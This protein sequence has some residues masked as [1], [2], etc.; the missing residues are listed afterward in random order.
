MFLACT[1]LNLLGGDVAAAF[2]GRETA[3]AMAFAR[4]RKR[5]ADMATTDNKLFSLYCDGLNS[6]CIHIEWKA[7]E[8]L[9]NPADKWRAVRD[10]PGGIQGVVVLALRAP[11]V[12]REEQRLKAGQEAAAEEARQKMWQGMLADKRK[13]Q[14]DRAV[15]VIQKCARQVMRRKEASRHWQQKTAKSGLERQKAEMTDLKKKFTRLQ[16][17]LYAAKGVVDH[18]ERSIVAYG[19]Q[20]HG[21]IEE[22]LV[23]DVKCSESQKSRRAAISSRKHKEAGRLLVE[24]ERYDQLRKFCQEQQDQLRVDMEQTAMHKANALQ[25]IAKINH[26]IKDTDMGMQRLQRKLDGG[27]MTTGY[28]RPPKHAGTRALI[29]ARERRFAAGC[30]DRL[31][32]ARVGQ[33]A[34]EIEAVAAT[35]VQ[36][37]VRAQQARTVLMQR[38][39]FVQSFV[40]MCEIEPMLE[41]R[42]V[43]LQAIARGV[44]LR[45]SLVVSATAA[46]ASSKRRAAVLEVAEENCAREL[47]LARERVLSEEEEEARAREAE[48]SVGATAGM[49]S[50]N[51]SPIFSDR[52][53]VV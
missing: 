23:L 6:L 9:A 17:S 47:L 19:Q 5:E 13:L 49:Q 14:V 15:F 34:S 38:R 26:D 22:I 18:L 44:A 4:Q 10:N 41:S 42:V 52:K 36:T 30:Y 37:A 46:V 3:K 25:T 24:F 51:M 39:E 16:T 48:D 2:A 27:L 7:E 20:Q 28:P 12:V 33:V 43:R 45:S 1:I 40:R 31:R 8:G 29:E 35:K 21:K 32:G 50:P 11:E 53:S